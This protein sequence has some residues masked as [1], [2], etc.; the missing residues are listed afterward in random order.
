ML[1]QI[2]VKDDKAEL[3][4]QLVEELKS[5]MID[6]FDI[7]SKDGTILSGDIF[8]EQE[9]LNRSNELK[10]NKVKPI[11]REEVFDGIC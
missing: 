6:R 1:L 8:D 7:V 9:L 3:F 5:S 11:S 2:S 10:Q 4:L